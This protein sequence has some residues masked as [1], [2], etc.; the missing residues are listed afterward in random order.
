MYFDIDNEFRTHFKNLKQVFLYITDECNLKCIQCLYKPH[1]FFQLKEKEIPLDVA[2][3]L[4]SDF[5]ELGAKKLT[6]L[7]GEPTLYGLSQNNEPLLE[8]IEK[9]KNMGYEYIRISTNGSFKVSLLENIKFKNLNE[10]AFSLDGYTSE[11]N[12]EIRGPGSF[13]KC[14]SNIKAAENLEYKTSITCCIHKKLLERD[15][16]GNTLLHNMIQFAESLNVNTINFHD[17]F[18]CGAPMDLW[19]GNIDPAIES[20]MEIYDEI[21]KNI[22]NKK[23]SIS[24]RLPICIITKDAFEQNASYYGFCPAKLGERVL[25]HPNGILR[26]CSNLICTSYGVAKFFNNKITWDTGRT[27]ELSNHEIDQ[28]TP[29][30]IRGKK[31]FGNYVPLCFSLKPNQDEFVWK[32]ISWERRNVSK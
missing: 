22:S 32:D 10:I 5:R 8:L 14:V 7:G 3:K 17:L 30:T 13:S 27:N 20:W 6:I 15:K 1:V 25:V 11:M 9:S 24:I 23:Y 19:S 26:I 29:C 2:L 28:S 18:K 21:R 4:L 31:D 16:E 12:D